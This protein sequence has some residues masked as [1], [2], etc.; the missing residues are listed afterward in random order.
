MTLIISENKEQENRL[1][2]KMNGWH[3]RIKLT[4]EGYKKEKGIS[5]LDIRVE[6][7][8]ASLATSVFHKESDTLLTTKF[9][10][11]IPKRG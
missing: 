10:S 8:K 9:D 6:I 2:E 3:E 11:N 7:E 1:F 4:R 5:F